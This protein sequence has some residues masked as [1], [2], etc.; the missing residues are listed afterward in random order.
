MSRRYDFQD[1][2][3]RF[4]STQ[5]Q[6]FRELS[7]AIARRILELLGGGT[8]PND[9]PGAPSNF[10]AS[11]DQEFRVVLDWDAVAGATGYNVYRAPIGSTAFTLLSQASTSD[12]VD[13]GLP[14]ETSY[15]YYVT[16]YNS[17][18][19]SGPSSTEIGTTADGAAPPLPDVPA[20][21]QVLSNEDTVTLGWDAFTGGTISC[22]IERSVDQANW[23]QVANTAGVTFN[24]ANVSIG[25]TF[26]YRAFGISATGVSSVATPTI[27]TTVVDGDTEA[28]PVPVLTNTTLGNKSVFVEW[29]GVVASDLAGYEIGYG[30]SSGVYTNTTDL[31]TGTEANVGGLTN[32]TQYYFAVRSVDTSLNENKSAWSNEQS[33]T[34]IQDLDP[35]LIEPPE[36][37]TDL[38]VSSP[39]KDEIR[40]GFVPGVTAT[41]RRHR[42]YAR[43]KPGELI[44][45]S[46][47]TTA[48]TQIDQVPNPGTVVGAGATIFTGSYSWYQNPVVW[49][50]YVTCVDTYGDESAPSEIVES[51]VDG[52]DWAQGPGSGPISGGNFN[53]DALTAEHKV[54]GYTF[55]YIIDVSDPAAYTG[56]AMERAAAIFNNRRNLAPTNP[57]YIQLSTTDK[58]SIA[59]LLPN[60]TVNRRLE[61]NTGAAGNADI[62]VANFDFGGDPGFES[63][64]DLHLVGPWDDANATMV[65]A[66]L[67]MRDDPLNFT[68][69]YKRTFKDED[70]KSKFP[71][72][73]G[74]NITIGDVTR[75]NAKLELWLWNWDIEV[76][77]KSG[78]FVGSNADTG[79]DFPSNDFW[80]GLGLCRLHQDNILPN[81]ERIGSHAID[82]RYGKVAL[83]GTYIDM[84]WQEASAVRCL[85]TVAGDFDITNC[86]I[87]RSG[88]SAFEYYTR[89]TRDA[90]LQYQNPAG[91]LSITGLR[92]WDEKPGLLGGVGRASLQGAP[93]FDFASLEQAVIMTDC[94]VIEEIPTNFRS[95]AAW[96]PSDPYDWRIY[97]DAVNLTN[98]II[99]VQA[100]GG[101]RLTNSD[102]VRGAFTIQNSLLYSRNPIEPVVDLADGVDFTLD[103]VGIYTGESADVY[104]Y[105]GTTATLLGTTNTTLRFGGAGKPGGTPHAI[106]AASAT[107]LNVAAHV[108]SLT[109]DYGITAGNI[110]STPLDVVLGDF[111]IDHFA[112]TD[113][114]SFSDYTAPTVPY[115]SPLTISPDWP[116]VAT[117]DAIDMYDSGLT[118]AAAKNVI[119]PQMRANR[120][121]RTVVEGQSM[122]LRRWAYKPGE[123]YGATDDFEIS[124]G[125]WLGGPTTNEHVTWEDNHT[126]LKI[127]D[128]EFRH[129]GTQ[130]PVF[131]HY[132]EAKGD[133]SRMQQSTVNQNPLVPFEY[134]YPKEEHDR[135][136]APGGCRWVLDN[137]SIYDRGE[138]RRYARPGIDDGS[139]VT[140][141]MR[142][143]QCEDMTITNSDFR[144]V[145]QEHGNYL[146]SEGPI[147]YENCTFQNCGGQGIQITQ[148]SDS[149]GQRLNPTANPGAEQP[150]TSQFLS[151]SHNRSWTNTHFIDCTNWSNQAQQKSSVI[152]C[153]NSGYPDNPCELIEMTD[154]SI[155]VGLTVEE[156][157]QE[158]IEAG[159]PEHTPYIHRNGASKQSASLFTAI[160]ESQSGLNDPS[161]FREG[162]S[163]S[164][165]STELF[166]QPFADVAAARSDNA[167][168]TVKVIKFT[169]CY[170]RQMDAANPMFRFDSVHT[171]L[172]E[173]C[174]FIHDEVYGTTQRPFNFDSGLWAYGDPSA[175]NYME[176][177]DLHGTHHVIFRNCRGEMRDASGNYEGNMTFRWD[178]PDVE[179]E[180]TF[181]SLDFQPNTELHFRGYQDG[182]TAGQVGQPVYDGPVRPGYMP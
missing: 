144:Y 40:V 28:P 160:V 74:N 140:W 173:N 117:I 179:G 141:L 38:T 12:Y 71:D 151:T 91:T 25:A 4:A 148:R 20:N 41:P 24:D 54:P 62:E 55:D 136:G 36:P 101:D 103:N 66:Q 122:A 65:D 43:V 176:N 81:S 155:I 157:I 119:V 114:F 97:T 100:K 104:G 50:F 51:A 48:W 29:E 86:R 39:D 93:F 115:L 27:S 128:R 52:S 95:P 170:F 129:P 92:H 57:D 154:C 180:Y 30:T 108:T 113:D 159:D 59:I 79:D 89:R 168:T 69:G 98:P 19:E 125:S 85:S 61:I 109:N 83:G 181:G 178:S 63:L 106:G 131:A 31:I 68:L 120:A 146:N 124:F 111:T 35:S 152:N 174:V 45:G 44:D 9:P 17:A 156:S 137:V 75:D 76:S 23:T 96:P 143:N 94:E 123:G 121:P 26:Y 161:E 116:A 16:A 21:F 82:A 64:V 72:G 7:D 118:R 105:A 47:P 70:N 87:R 73:A 142:V 126:T 153:Y 84:P 90:G 8:V 77:G 165:I 18:G 3:D 33:K 149:W 13:S 127:H 11:T 58:A 158:R 112:V 145:H 32:L 80:V 172:F 56:D 99:R 5:N 110:L 166:K 14:A 60:E 130:R 138:V 164:G 135:W 78:V 132:P 49:Q 88:G 134:V 175:F 53:G 150:E 37:P 6:R 182:R 171:I 46:V 67:A 147:T 107:G 2:L 177:A 133:Y 139:D 167:A 34:P 162:C 10:T 1:I 102:Y 42:L 15:R 163:G 169:N 22:R